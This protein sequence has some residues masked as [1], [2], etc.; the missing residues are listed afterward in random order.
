MGICS[1]SDETE[2]AACPGGEAGTA[3]L[4]SHE[5]HGGGGP[6]RAKEPE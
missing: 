6:F 3:R 2:R 1:Q 5:V 4:V